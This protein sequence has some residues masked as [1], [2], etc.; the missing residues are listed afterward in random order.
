MPPPGTFGGIHWARSGVST[1]LTGKVH[2]QKQ[3]PEVLR[4]ASK[5]GMAQRP[6]MSHLLGRRLSADRLPVARLPLED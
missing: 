5:P 4:T 3:N 1:R 6:E 2:P